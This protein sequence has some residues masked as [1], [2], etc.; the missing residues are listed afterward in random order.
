MA[1]A[2]GLLANAMAAAQE[3]G[4]APENPK[5]ASAPSAKTDDVKTLKDQVA[6]QQTQLTQQQSQISTQQK[7]IDRLEKALEEQQRLL[8]ALEGK[9]SAT[10]ETVAVSSPP[11][12]AGVG[13]TVGSATQTPAHDQVASLTPIIPAASKAA[14]VKAATPSPVAAMVQ[15]EGGQAPEAPKTSPLSVRIGDAEFTPVGFMDLTEVFRTT[16]VGSGIG[17]TFGSIPFSNTTTGQLS[18]SRFSMQ[19]SRLG[20]SVTSKVMGFDVKGYVETDFLGNSA[21]TVFITSNADTLRSRLYWVDAR[22]GGF[23]FLGGQSWSFL[24]PNRD[25]LSPNPS[26]IFYSLDMDTNYQVGL[27]WTR[28]AQFRVVYHASDTLAA[29]ISVENSQQYVG[30]ATLPSKLPA[31]EV[32]TGS[33]NTATPNLLPDFVAKV[34]YDPSFKGLHQHVEVAGLLTNAKIFDPVTFTKNSTEGGGLAVNFNLQP[35]NNLH[36]IL[37]TFYSDGGGRY[38]FALGPEFVVRPNQAGDLAP[39]MLRSYSGIAG[40]EYQVNKATQLYAYY[41]GAYFG[42]YVSYDPATLKLIGYGYGPDP[43]NG[44]TPS[45]NTQNREIQEGTFGVI[46]TFWKDPHYGALQLI[47]QYSYLTRSPWA[48]T[49]ISAGPPP[50]FGPANAH[51]SMGYVDLRYV[52]P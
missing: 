43:K 22:K 11:P 38:I 24:T 7:Q 40:L 9:A 49:P 47:T 39:A 41:G 17:T 16:N 12:A 6:Q 29:G 50:I 14:E 31:S 10:T 28:Q 37:N 44:G 13:G 35:V 20:A 52:L 8:Q 48:N 27:T 36:V 42:Q 18:E 15:E 3:S 23:E 25:G 32:E 33:G 21:S 26:D 45:P 51:L 46:Q 2:A 19:N 34:A 5:A 4:P 30:S 1:L